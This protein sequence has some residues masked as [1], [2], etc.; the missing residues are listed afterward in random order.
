[1][2][3]D[4]EV[5]APALGAL[6]VELDPGLGVG[7]TMTTIVESPGLV[8]NMV[9]VLGGGGGV[10]VGDTLLGVVGVGFGVLL[11]VVLVD[12][13]ESIDEVDVA[14]VGAVVEVSEVEVEEGMVGVADGFEAL[15][16]VEADDGPGSVRV[17]RSGPVK[18]VEGAAFWASPDTEDS[19]ATS[20]SEK[21]AT[22]LEVYMAATATGTVL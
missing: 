20:A 1:M 5:V 14:D 13:V 18:P 10:V 16:G 6:D 9:L 2:S 11:G 15:V 21:K 19:N 3:V 22:D 17:G 7:V 8:G 4:D 12:E